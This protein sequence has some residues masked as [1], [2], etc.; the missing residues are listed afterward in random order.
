M[1]STSRLNAGASYA[2]NK[3]LNSKAS[4]TLRLIISELNSLGIH[5]WLAAG[6][7][8]GMFRIFL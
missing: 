8:L 7:L 1:A 2:Q 4:P 5:Y 3:T 6:T